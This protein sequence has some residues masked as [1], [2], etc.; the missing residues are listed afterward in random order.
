MK[1][2]KSPCVGLCKFSGKNDWCLGCGRTRQECKE[3]KRMKPYA[4]IR[5][6]KDLDRRMTLLISDSLKKH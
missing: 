3:W 2:I 4:R 5:L 6:T 1:S